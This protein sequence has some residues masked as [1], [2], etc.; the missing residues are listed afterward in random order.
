[1]VSENTGRKKF[2]CGWKGASDFF[3]LE[4]ESEENGGTQEEEMGGVC[5]GGIFLLNSL[6][7]LFRYMPFRAVILSG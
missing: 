5:G 2:W 3:E 4:K 6:E 1:M 7:S